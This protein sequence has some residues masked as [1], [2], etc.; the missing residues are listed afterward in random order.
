M[1]T[2]AVFDISDAKRRLQ[3][4]QELHASGALS[5]EAYAEGK[6]EL[7]RRILDWALRESPTP[8]AKAASTTK[9]AAAGIAAGPHS[10]S[11]KLL[12]SLALFVLIV[13]GAGYSFMG[14]RAQINNEGAAEA[15]MEAPAGA[16]A[17]AGDPTAAGQP[18]TTSTEQI[19]AMADK[20]AAK[21]KDK[22]QDAEGWAMLARSYSVIGRLPEAA[23]AY[24]KATALRG[25]DA[26]LLADY[27]D[28]L[29]LKNNRSLAGE[30]MKVV[31]RALKVDPR[32]VKA[33]SLAGTYA[34]ETMDYA[35]AVKYWEQAVQFGS[36]DGS[37]LVEQI[38]A[39]LVEARQRAGLPPAPVAAP[40]TSRL[41]QLAQEPAAA[42]TANVAPEKAISGTVTLAPALARSAKPDDTVFIF[43]RPAEGSR[44]PLA[45][46]RKQVKDLPIQFTLDDSMAMSP[47]T[48]LSLAGKVIVGARISKTA[49]AVPAVGDLSGQSAVVAVGT[50]G[51]MIEIKDV[52]K[53]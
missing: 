17:G 5:S 41:A 39:G 35:G 15:G 25:N 2:S 7:E 42:D 16:G 43:A 48:R 11:A 52:L 26:A 23:A 30:P 38:Q 3:Q 8:V 18:H 31:Q 46:L 4:L 19:A 9:P 13:A 27:A 49:N 10:P 14:G 40:A 22:P 47:A 33:L 36:A 28:V 1:P 34:F 29:A 53:Q 6:T 44:M 20:L 32:N 24:E 37:G 50:K 21:L 12:V 51:L 45:I